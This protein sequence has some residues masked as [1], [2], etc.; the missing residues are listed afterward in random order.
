M[1]VAIHLKDMLELE[2]CN[3]KFS[4]LSL[5]QAHE[6]NNAIVKG[7][8]GAIG[9][10]TDT[11][12]LRRWLISGPEVSRIVND[13]EH[14]FVRQTNTSDKHHE[15]YSSYQ[16][17]E[18][19]EIQSVRHKFEEYGNA[20]MEEIDELCH[21]T[22]RTVA[23]QLVTVT[24]PTVEE[25]GKKLFADYLDQRLVQNDLIM[26]LLLLL[27]LSAE[28]KQILDYHLYFLTLHINLSSASLFREA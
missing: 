11:S 8:D 15:Q 14:V 13:L 25:V 1:M 3:H 10:L 22:T 17:H 7:A 5:D 28:F 9:L 18:L 23:A 19:H 26:L 16:Q 12:A 24:V 2:T 27:W 21:L 20:F 6:Q 4:A